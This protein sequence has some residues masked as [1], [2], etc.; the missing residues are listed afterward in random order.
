MSVA[1]LGLQKEA[2]I[3]VTVSTPN[4]TLTTT[5]NQTTINVK[6]T[7]SF[8][9]FDRKLVGL[10][11]R[12]VEKIRV[13]DDDAPAFN[14]LHNF[15]AQFV[16]VTDGGGSQAIPRDRSITVPRSSLQGDPGLGDADEIRCRVTIEPVGMPVA[17]TGLSDQEVLAG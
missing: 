15:P 3:M 2:T 16:P 17:A 11:L 13:L 4:L 14:T 10:G 8:Q 1:G 7:A 5:G 12:F 6:Y 9:Q